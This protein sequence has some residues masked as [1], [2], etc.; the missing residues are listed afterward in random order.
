VTTA[1]ELTGTKA[2]CD[3]VTGKFY[4]QA[5]RQEPA[6]GFSLQHSRTTA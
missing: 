5:Y 3:K 6:D 2:A 1:I 4:T